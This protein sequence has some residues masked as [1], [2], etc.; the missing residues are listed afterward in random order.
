[1]IGLL[2][3]LHQP[4]YRD[5]VTKIPMMPWTRLHAL[6]GYRD[7]LLESVESG[8]PWTLNIVPGLWEQLLHYAEGG[9][10]S[11]L[12]TS[13][14]GADTL[15]P[16]EIDAVLRTFPTGHPSMRNTPRYRELE[17]RILAGRALTV[18]DLRDLQVLSTLVWFGATARRD[19]PVLDELIAKGGGFDES[20]KAAMLGVQDQVLAQLP[21]LLARFGETAGPALSTTPLH[22]PILPLLVNLRH[23][24]RST[25]DPPDVDF[26]WPQDARLQLDRGRQAM[27]RWTGRAPRGCWP[28]EGS[29]SPEVVQLIAE[30]G[31]SWL[32][33]DDGVLA[34]SR[35]ERFHRGSGGWDLG[36]GLTGFFRDHELSDRIGFDYAR[37]DAAE[38]VADFA[39]RAGR[40]EGVAVVAL[41]GENPWEAFP[42]AGAEFRKRLIEVL[43]RDGIT[44]D[45]AAELS[46]VGRVE[47]LHSGSWIG[48]NFD[49]WA[50]APEDH[51][52]WAMLARARDR[53]EVAESGRDEAIE[54]LLAAEGSDWFWWY[55][56]EFDTPFADA[57][58]AAFRAHVAAAYRAIGSE[59]P[60]DVGQPIAASGPRITPPDRAIAPQ[61]PAITQWIGAG[62]WA[63]AQG[64]MARAAGAVV[65]YGWGLDGALWLRL[66][67]GVSS[68]VIAGQTLDV[69]PVVRVDVEP[70]VEVRIDGQVAELGG[71]DWVV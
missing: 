35:I 3:H 56:P 27:A 39:H 34:R 36:H 30:A 18:A 53:V 40:I 62:R 6:R 42:D 54:H 10:D 15:E 14:R 33:T 31:F 51:A 68:L 49:I 20:D 47:H 5:P 64:S 22:H 1:M 19:F 8:V 43:L 28:S 70:G 69:E 59:I 24:G 38:A 17:D 66:P 11:H 71:P 7:L 44:L 21:A 65:L 37:W 67:P 13:R 55:G 12:D 26:E 32:C 23:A 2:W 48:A 25:A 60:A 52:A 45:A 46:P 41:D 63:L 50:G 9:S 58:D 16:D 4:E 29:V 57:F 61:G